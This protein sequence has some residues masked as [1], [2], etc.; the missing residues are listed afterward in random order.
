MPGFSEQL[1]RTWQ[2]EALW[3]QKTSLFRRQQI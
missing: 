1:N 2:P 3:Q